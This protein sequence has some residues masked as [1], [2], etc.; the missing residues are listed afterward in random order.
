MFVIFHLSSIYEHTRFLFQVFWC[1]HLSGVDIR[2]SRTGLYR[3]GPIS[4]INRGLT[5][6]TTDL[7][8]G[9]Y[10]EQSTS[11]KDAEIVYVVQDQR[12]HQLSP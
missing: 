9:N 7:H 1:S 4:E 2:R 8:K 5:T 12:S 11:S 3:S 10:H 6:R